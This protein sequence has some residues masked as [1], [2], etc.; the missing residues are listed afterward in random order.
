MLNDLGNETTM[1][2]AREVKFADDVVETKRAAPKSAEIKQAESWRSLTSI[3]EKN[4]TEVGLDV[5]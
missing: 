3:Y 1:T 5:W 4:S 2:T